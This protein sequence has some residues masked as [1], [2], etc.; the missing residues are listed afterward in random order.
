MSATTVEESTPPDRK[1]P[2]ATSATMRKGLAYGIRSVPP[3]QWTSIVRYVTPLLPKR[4]Q[5]TL[6]GD[7]LHKLA[8]LLM[9]A[10]PESLYHRLISQ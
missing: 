8:N 9:M 4:W 7:K 6:P 1:A 10:D 3:S 2:N 5:M